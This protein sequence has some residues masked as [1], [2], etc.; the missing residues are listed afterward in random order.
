M[1]HVKFFSSIFSSE[2]HDSVLSSGV[3]VHKLGGIIDLIEQND[4]AI[5]LSIMFSHFSS[6]K[7]FASS[8]LSVFFLGS[9]HLASYSG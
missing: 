2:K 5:I 1:K 7:S 9:G 8:L 4:P 6:S 3:V